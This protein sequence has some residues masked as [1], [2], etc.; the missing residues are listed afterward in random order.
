M[1]NPQPVVLP[2]WTASDFDPE[3]M[4]ARFWYEQYR[5]QR[6]ENQQLRQ[7]LSQLQA[8]VEQLREALRKLTQRSSDNSS[9]PASSDVYKKES[10]EIKR[11]KQKQGPK[12]G[13][14][15]T[16]RNEFAEVDHQIE[17]HRDTCPTCGSPVEAIV[18]APV[19]RHQIAEL[20][21][22]PVE[23]WQYHRRK[24]QCPVCGW[25][26]YAELPLGCRED[27]SY[28]ALLSSLVAGGWVRVRGTFEL[29]EATLSG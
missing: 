29:A 3:D 23:V 9:Q 2:D 15:G 4:G 28:G 5:Q 13:H 12:Y 8:E 10:K 20:V 14:E 19:K 25:Q 24:Y 11:R 27:F 1:E 7:Q 6:E 18:E 26:G 21:A 22:K 16:T 17:L